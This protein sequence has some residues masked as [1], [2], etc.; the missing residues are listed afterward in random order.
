LGFVRRRGIHAGAGVDIG[1][2]IEEESS[3]IEES[4]SGG[5]VEEGRATKREQAAAGLA[6]I[7]QF[8]IS[9]VDQRRRPLQ[10]DL[11]FAR[12]ERRSP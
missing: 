4:V 12:T 1:P 8:R 5:D 11:P 3:G 6:T 10:V 2:A 9:T 7:D